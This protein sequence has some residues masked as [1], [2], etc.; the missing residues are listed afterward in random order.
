[1]LSIRPPNSVASELYLIALQRAPADCWI[2]NVRL[3][4][5]MHRGQLGRPAEAKEAEGQVSWGKPQEGRC[6]KGTSTEQG[7]EWEKIQKSR[8]N[9]FF[10]TR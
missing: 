3:V 8:Q 6:R 2:P 7:Q 9:P 5:S 4:G 10:K 1:M